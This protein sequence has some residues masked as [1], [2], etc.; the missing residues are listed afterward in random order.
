MSFSSHIRVVAVVIFLLLTGFAEGVRGCLHI[1]D[2]H[3]LSESAREGLY[4]HHC[5]PNENLVSI[6]M[7][8][9]KNQTKDKNVDDRQRSSI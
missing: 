3:Y 6:T 1:P 7:S 8:Q 4:P 5:N 2:G 9:K